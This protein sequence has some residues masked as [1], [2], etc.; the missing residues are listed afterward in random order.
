[1]QLPPLANNE[2]MILERLLEPDK[3]TLPPSA[4]EAILAIAFSSADKTRMHQL[5]AK[6]QSGTLSV[7]EQAEAEA[8]SRVGSLLGVLKSKARRSLKN[9]PDTNGTAKAR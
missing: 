2:A 3:P 9:C 5:A 8:Y 1:M 4:C 6:A 7:E